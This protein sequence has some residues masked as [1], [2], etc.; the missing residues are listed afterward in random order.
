MKKKVMKKRVLY[1]VCLALAVLLLIPSL[2]ACKKQ[3]DGATSVDNGDKSTVASTEGAGDTG[4]Q[5]DANGYLM[6][7]LDGIDL[8]GAEIHVLVG[9]GRSDCFVN[10]SAIG[11][12]AVNLA[13]Y[14]RNKS[15]ETR[16]N[17]ELNF[18]EEEDGYY[19]RGSFV[20]RVNALAGSDTIDLIGVY[21][22]TA[23][24]LMIE[25]LSEDMMKSKNLNFDAPWWSDLMV[26]S[27]RIYDKLYY[28]T[29][30]ISHAF[31]GES[32]VLHLNKNL[33]STLQV[34]DFI[35]TNYGYN[36]IYDLV[37]S[38]NWTIDKLI[39]VAD[40]VGVDRGEVGVKDEPDT[41]GFIGYAAYAVDGI[42][43]A[44]GLKCLENGEDGSVIISSDM[45]SQKAI[46]LEEKWEAFFKS[47]T[48]I[49]NGSVGA[50]SVDNVYGRA[51]KNGTGLFFCQPLSETLTAQDFAVGVIPMPKYD[52]AQK[53][54]ITTTGFGPTLWSV[55]RAST[56]EFE[57]VCAVLECLASQGHR[58]V[59]PL[60]VETMLS[61]RQDTKD[62]YD[63]VQLV[64]ASV[65]IDKGR[66][67][68]SIF[69]ENTW[70][71]W[72]QAFQSEKTYKSKYDGVAQSLVEQAISLNSLIRNM[73]Q[74]YGDA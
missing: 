19:N 25:G 74:L 46:A 62:D 24:N 61:N 68:D 38:G 14:S 35:K 21:S 51:W 1:A 42:Y 63:M 28:A 2:A 32:I 69:N 55:A 40:Y 45:G 15:V 8:D 47:P 71:I 54:Y 73:E 29:G 26:E 56:N 70:A 33:A 18:M 27:S 41:Y 9:T 43:W 57:D 4:P 22:L 64:F 53:N 17:C 49:C 13:V 11:G 10:S 30:D 67:C 50:A 65:M 37:R 5:Y 59:I 48:A 6:D 12:D 72:R 52:E 36:T 23:S 3:P 39:E 34:D 58:Q 31:Y 16:L 44:S 66:V 60:Y 7:D 20:T